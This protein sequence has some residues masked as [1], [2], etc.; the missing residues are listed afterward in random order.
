M[1]AREPWPRCSSVPETDV[2]VLVPYLGG[3]FGAGLRAWPHVIL[4]ALAARVVGRPVKLVLTR[5]QMFTSVGHRPETLQRVRLGAARDGRLVAIEHEA[6]VDAR[7]ARRRRRRA[8]HAGHRQRV[9]LPERRRHTTGGCG[10]NI[11]T[12]VRCARPGEAEGNFALESALDELAY[13]AGHR[14]DRAAAA[15]LRRGPPGVRPAVVE[16]GPARVLPRSAPS[17]S[18]GRGATPRSARC[19]TATGSIGYGMA[20]VDVRAC[21]A[22]CQARVVDPPRR[23]RARAQ[24][25]HRHRH[26]HLHDHHAGRRRAARPRRRPGPVRARR[27]R[28]AAGAALRRLGAG[29]VAGQRRPRRRGASWCGRSW[30]WSPTTSSP[31]RGWRPDDVA[32]ATARI[33]RRR[34]P[35]G[36]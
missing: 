11:P 31:L 28:P 21:Q 22:R 13:T 23:H 3:G 9:R 17:G 30:T 24:R 12:R 19:A 1:R 20:G 36:R 5:P 29:R 16:Q 26:R 18:A 32:V 33:H 10:C 25:G 2:R 7:G 15:Q 6:T 27:Q 14:P 8:G 34:R 35:V 4:T